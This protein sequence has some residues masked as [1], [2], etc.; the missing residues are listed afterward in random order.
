MWLKLMMMLFLI[1]EQMIGFICFRHSSCWSRVKGW[2]VASTSTD[3]VYGDDWFD[4]LFDDL[5]N[6]VFDKDVQDAAIKRAD[7]LIRD[8]CDVQKD[9][10]YDLTLKNVIEMERDIEV[11]MFLILCQWES[12]K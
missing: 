11:M 5:N 6:H 7:A 8:I 10:E 1:E 3:V 9:V 4:K 12:E 2:K